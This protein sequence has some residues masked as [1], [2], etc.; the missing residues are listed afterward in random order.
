MFSEDSDLLADLPPDLLRQLESFQLSRDLPSLAAALKAILEEYFGVAQPQTTQPWATV[1]PTEISVERFTRL[2]RQVN[3]LSTEV[4]QL[5]LR[6]PQIPPLPPPAAV[7]PPLSALSPRSM[8]YGFDEQLFDTWQD[9]AIAQ[10][11]NEHYWGHRVLVEIMAQAG[12]PELTLAAFLTQ[13]TASN[14]AGLELQLEPVTSSATPRILAVTF[15]PPQPPEVSFLNSGVHTRLDEADE[16]VDE[17][18]EVLYDFLEPRYSP[19][20]SADKRSDRQ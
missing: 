20:F 7:A 14:A 1:E 2:E 3:H 17:P 4:A 18:D 6:L 8:S 9:L 16:F 11:G 12:F 10:V 15:Q 13:L 5:L 19:E